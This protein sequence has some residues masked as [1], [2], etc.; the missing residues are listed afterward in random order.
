MGTAER[1]A[2]E[3]EERR[4]LI[5]KKATRLILKKGVD[6]VSM[7]DIAAECELGKATLYL[8][9]PGKEAIL[10]AI[11]INASSRFIEYV[12]MRLSAFSSG[13]E[14][15]RTLWMSYL[16]IYGESI[17]IFV[18]I[19]IKNYIAPGFPLVSLPTDSR[20]KTPAG[21]LITLIADVLARGVADGT[22]DSQIESEKVARTIIMITTG[23]I[24]NVARL[25]REQRKSD[26]IKAEM[27]STFEIILRGLA[28][29]GTDRS[30]LELPV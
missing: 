21:R 8:Y 20:F 24:E 11:F 6:A 12:E 16:D 18:L 13:L 22:L 10:E 29:N 28:A 19:G 5:L 27:K 7:Q 4:E 25:P 17:D 1:K 23:I 26:L 14:S 30:L 9:F 3:K 2:R 15:I